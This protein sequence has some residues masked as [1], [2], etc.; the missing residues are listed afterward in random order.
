MTNLNGKNVVLTGAAGGLGH[1][2]GKHLC[3]EGAHIIGID[4]NQSALDDWCDEMRSFGGE[5]VG[6]A[7]DLSQLKS[8]HELVQTIE[9]QY[10]PVDVL[11]NNAGIS[12]YRAFDDCD[13]NHTQLVLDINLNAVMELTRQLLPG[14]RV[15]GQ[16][17]VVN[18]ASLAAKFG[19]PYDAVYAAS[20]AG[21][22][23]WGHSLRQE[24]YG[25]PIR[26]SAVCPGYISQSGMFVH[27]Q[28]PAPRLAGSSSPSL[29]AKKV[30]QAIRT[31]RAEVV[32][33]QDFITQFIGKFLMAIRQFLPSFGD[34]L[35]RKIGVND[36]NQK[37][38]AIYREKRQ[39][40]GAKR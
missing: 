32:V 15:R 30:I 33:N 14:F 17:H 19:H 21:L 7:W 26:V 16:G 40:V 34:D 28:L 18:I 11:I 27:T 37:R 1:H 23:A 4:L 3:L 25:T 2:I 38:A 9:R 20:K 8:L 31:N 39:P 6:L 10:G 24:L 22:L 29:V 5:A 35:F 12:S 13:L 36:L